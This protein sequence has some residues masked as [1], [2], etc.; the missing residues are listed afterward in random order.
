MK[1][2]FFDYKQLYLRDRKAILKI[3]NQISSQGAFILQKEV[4]IF[5]KKN[6]Q[7]YKIKIC[8]F[9]CKWY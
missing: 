2:P 9:S 4:N 5:E 7:L 3:F 8:N 6:L 1:V